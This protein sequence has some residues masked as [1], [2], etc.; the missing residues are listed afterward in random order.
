M[1]QSLIQSNKHNGQSARRFA[2]ASLEASR[3]LD[4][5]TANNGALRRFKHRSGCQDGLEPFHHHLA[6]KAEG[7]LTFQVVF[8]L[9]IG[10]L[11]ETLLSI[12]CDKY[13]RKSS[14]LLLNYQK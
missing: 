14:M 2:S 4:A 12:T 1:S 13:C 11:F 9:R 3:L 10:S 8:C 6:N 5:P 7:S